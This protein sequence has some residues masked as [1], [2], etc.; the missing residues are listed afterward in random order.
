[1][2]K[3]QKPHVGGD[4]GNLSNWFGYVGNFEGI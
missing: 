3:V 1:M 2:K 4:V